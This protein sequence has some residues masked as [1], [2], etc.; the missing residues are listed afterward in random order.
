MVLVRPL[1][2][3]HRQESD[4]PFP[5]SCKQISS[6]AKEIRESIATAIGLEPHWESGEVKRI[7]LIRILKYKKRVRILNTGCF[8]SRVLAGRAVDPD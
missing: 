1:S 2:L 7:F 3:D 4:T 6:R 5:S 8:Y